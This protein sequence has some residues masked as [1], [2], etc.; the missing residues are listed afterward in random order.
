MEVTRT[1]ADFG[2]QAG[3]RFQIA[4]LKNVRPRLDHGFQSTR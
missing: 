1:G 4:G 2:V 3:D